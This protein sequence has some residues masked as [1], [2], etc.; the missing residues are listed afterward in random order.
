MNVKFLLDGSQV[1]RFHTVPT[2]QVNTVGHHSHGVAML[3]WGI[4][5]GQASAALLMA[6]LT[7]DLG[8]QVIGDIP[9]PTKRAL[10]PIGMEAINE[11]E[12]RTLRSAG[13]AFP[14]TAVEN[15]ILKLAD[16]LDGMLFCIGERILGNRNIEVV[17]I[18]FASYINQLP[19]PDGAA[20][21]LAQ[22]NALWEEACA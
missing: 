5:Q 21:I 4:T 18:R 10:G 13:Y 3:A 20:E 7:H 15:N 19:A 11:M 17:F 14:L 9:S 6:A 22:I 12:D 16:C 8:E 2:V 1:R